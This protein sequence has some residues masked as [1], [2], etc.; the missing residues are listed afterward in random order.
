MSYF[1]VSWLAIS[2]SGESN[3]IRSVIKAQSKNHA[4]LDDLIRLGCLELGTSIDDI[5]VTQGDLSKGGA[6]NSFTYEPYPNSENV[7]ELQEVVVTV[8]GEATTL[9][10][11]KN[12]DQQLSHSYWCKSKVF[13]PLIKWTIADDHGVVKHYLDDICQG[14]SL[15]DAAEQAMVAVIVSCNASNDMDSETARYLANESEY[16]IKNSRYELI[17]ARMMNKAIIDINGELSEILFCKDD[18]DLTIPP[19]A[20]STLKSIA[21]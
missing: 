17:S 13:S 18:R 5:D 12:K 9:L 8:D 21:A 20:W 14:H 10:M 19:L 11:A 1:L 7:I 15:S 16:R 6:T 4:V 3:K 2:K